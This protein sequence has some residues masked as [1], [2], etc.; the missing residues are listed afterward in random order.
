[1]C[2]RPLEL[3]GK[4]MQLHPQILEG[5]A[6]NVLRAVG[7]RKERGAI[8]PHNFGRNRSTY[9]QGRRNW[10]GKGG[11]CAPRFWQESQQNLFLPKTLD[12]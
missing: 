12:N 1:M 10:G 8:A 6:A 9:A 4:G 11:N 3:G 2:S 7:T 5:V